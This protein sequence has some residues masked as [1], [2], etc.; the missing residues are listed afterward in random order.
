MDLLS[1]VENF[2]ESWRPEPGDRL[3]GKVVEIDERDGGFGPYPVVTIETEDGTEVTA[4]LFHTVA[5]RE[6]AR[7]R[8][9]VGDRIAI[10]YFGRR[11]DANYESYR[12][13][14]EKVNPLQKQSPNWDAIESEANEELA[15][16]DVATQEGIEAELG[17][18][19]AW[20]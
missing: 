11:G 17:A 15:S 14:V 2:P 20:S 4:H 5:R 18:Q 7:Q 19:E 10:K 1:R 12:V 8:P 3:A 6:L 16:S 13:A 9:E